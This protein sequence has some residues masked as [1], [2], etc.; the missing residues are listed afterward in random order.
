MIHSEEDD[1]ETLE[2]EKE[3]LRRGG[4]GNNDFGN[5]IPVKEEYRP[6]PSEFSE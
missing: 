1:E 5:T 4:K 3:Q 2:W 6:A